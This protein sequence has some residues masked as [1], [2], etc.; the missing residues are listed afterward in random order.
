MVYTTLPFIINM[1]NII[2][3]CYNYKENRATMISYK[4]CMYIGTCINVKKKIYIYIYYILMKLTTSISLWTLFR[5]KY[6]KL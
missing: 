5:K 2:I 1:Y 4:Y 6:N 3:L